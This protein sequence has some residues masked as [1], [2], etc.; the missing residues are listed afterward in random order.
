MAKQNNTPP[1]LMAKKQEGAKKSLERGIAI[2][3]LVKLSGSDVAKMAKAEQDKLIIIIGQL[4]GLV[5]DKG[6]VK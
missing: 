6:T 2:T 1:V 3:E 5:D 4:L